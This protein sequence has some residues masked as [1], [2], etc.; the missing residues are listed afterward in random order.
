M[1]LVLA[2]H[3]GGDTIENPAGCVNRFFSDGVPL[4]RES[5]YGLRPNGALTFGPDT[6]ASPCPQPKS[7]T[8]ATDHPT[9][10]N[11]YPLDITGSFGLVLRRVTLSA[12]IGLRDVFRQFL[13]CEDRLQ[14]RHSGA[15]VDEREA[16]PIVA[17]QRPRVADEV[18]RH[19]GAIRGD[20]SRGKR[21]LAVGDRR[22]GHLV[23]PHVINGARLA[24]N[25][26]HESR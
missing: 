5:S 22:Q 18:V 17:D 9:N 3:P 26:R 21:S 11:V 20:P 16:G 7:A 14:P 24:E 13:V 10:R 12:P 23:V 1:T 19:V 4:G 25:R 15:A 2:V 6:S 8:V